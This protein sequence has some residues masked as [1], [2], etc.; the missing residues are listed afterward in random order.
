[1]PTKPAMMQDV[2]HLREALE[3]KIATSVAELVLRLVSMENRLVARLKDERG[4]RQLEN[5]FVTSLLEKDRSQIRTLTDGLDALRELSKD[6]R[7]GDMPD[8][9][10]EATQASTF[11]R[12][13]DALQARIEDVADLIQRELKQVRAD[14]IAERE[15]AMS[16]Q[17]AKLSELVERAQAAS[18]SKD[19]VGENDKKLAHLEGQLSDFMENTNARFAAV[20]APPR[21]TSGEYVSP[22]E[23]KAGVAQIDRMLEQQHTAEANLEKQMHGRIKELEQAL[24][25]RVEQLEEG[26]TSCKDLCGKFDR[27]VSPSGGATTED[28]PGWNSSHDVNNGLVA[29]IAGLECRVNSME[30]DRVRGRSPSSSFLPSP[31]AAMKSLTSWNV[32]RSISPSSAPPADIREVLTGPGLHKD[33]MKQKRRVQLVRGITKRML[34]EDTGAASMDMVRAASLGASLHP[35]GLDGIG[36]SEAP[37][38]PRTSMRATRSSMSSPSA[39]GLTIPEPDLQRQ[40]VEVVRQALQGEDWRSLRRSS[41]IRAASRGV[42]EAATVAAGSAVE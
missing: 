5:S 4:E 1:M 18:Q 7:E 12:K 38:G 21:A 32:S 26:M 30:E 22:Q 6:R 2:H 27:K 36:E 39:Y 19:A 11:S 16:A 17:Y 20:T 24:R 25:S 33:V 23:L 14:L 41:S 13:C 8:V 42:E 35:Q 10:Q 3:A 31:M 37:V 15:A 9:P 40:R 29:R 28:P 34:A